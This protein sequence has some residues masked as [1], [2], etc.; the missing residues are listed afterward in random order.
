MVKQVMISKLDFFSVLE[1]KSFTMLNYSHTPMEEIRLFVR[2]RSKQLY[3][4]A[5]KNY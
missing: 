1:T 2:P 5:T 4:D 3:V